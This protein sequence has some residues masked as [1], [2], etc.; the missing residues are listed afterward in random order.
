MSTELWCAII[1][2]LVTL[3]T[4]I[5]TWHFT[6]KKDSNA[7]K[8]LVLA[9]VAELKDDITAVNANVQQQFAVQTLQIE[10]LSERVEKHNNVMERMFK[11]EQRVDDMVKV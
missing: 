8:A 10:T 1:S 4:A 3:V 2:G 11:L 7:N 5:G 9:K 6:A